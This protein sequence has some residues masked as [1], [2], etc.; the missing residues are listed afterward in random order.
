LKRS[1]ITIACYSSLAPSSWSALY[2]PC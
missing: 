2:W 1:T